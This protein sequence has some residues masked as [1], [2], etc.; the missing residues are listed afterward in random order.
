ME[1][2]FKG[3]WIPERIWLDK[4][5]TVTERVI[6]AQLED[7]IQDPYEEWGGEKYLPSNEEC[8]EY[9]QVSRPTVS[10][11]LKKFKKLGIL[12]I[13]FNGRTRFVY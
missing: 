5:L 2:Q 1:R 10:R 9:L 4:R 3:V 7:L 8:C 6:L 11:A 13:Y 12:K